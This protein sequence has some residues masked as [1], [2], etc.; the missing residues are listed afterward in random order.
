MKHYIL[1][2]VYYLHFFFRFS[3]HYRY[4]LDKYKKIMF[5]IEMN[6]RKYGIENEPIPDLELIWDDIVI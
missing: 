2:K 1:E 4:N 5:D 6:S 3:P